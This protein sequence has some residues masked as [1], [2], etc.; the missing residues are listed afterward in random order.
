MNKYCIAVSGGCDS[1][2]LLDK[3]IKKGMNIIVAHVNYQKRETAWRDEEIVRKFCESH[4]VPFF[5]KYCNFPQHLYMM[6]I[7]IIDSV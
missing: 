1:M 7:K 2:T 4:H 6:K 3:C 5:V